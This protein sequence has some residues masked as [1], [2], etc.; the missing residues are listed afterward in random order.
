MYGGTPCPDVVETNHT[1]DLKCRDEICQLSK[2]YNSLL[3][4][5]GL[6]MLVYTGRVCE[7]GEVVCNG[8]CIIDSDKD[9]IPDD[10]VK[11]QKLN[12]S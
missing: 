12:C 8:E 9:C 5:T 3:S 1:E 2:I 11:N 6:I 7:A 10:Q 4:N